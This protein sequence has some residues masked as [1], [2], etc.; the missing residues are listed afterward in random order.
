MTPCLSDW[1]RNICQT[2][3]IEVDGEVE[4]HDLRHA[5]DGGKV[6]LRVSHQTEFLLAH[7]AL[8]QV[9]IDALDIWIWRMKCQNNSRI[10][11]AS[12]R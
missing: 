9:S 3:H 12:N 5:G 10:L 2:Y 8:P 4:G 6:G 11:T 1:G 7:L